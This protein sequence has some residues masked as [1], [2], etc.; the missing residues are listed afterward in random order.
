MPPAL[1]LDTLGITECKEV[2]V[3][4]DYLA[5]S[6]L[7]AAGAVDGVPLYRVVC[8]NRAAVGLT[9]LT[10]QAGPAIRRKLGSVLGKPVLVEIVA[11]PIEIV[12][13]TQP[14]MAVTA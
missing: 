2:R 8:D 5:G 7:E 6:R 1:L 3:A 10:A 12:T 14:E 11:Q 9:W 4:R 13:A